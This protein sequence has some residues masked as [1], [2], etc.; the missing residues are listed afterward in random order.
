MFLTQKNTLILLSPIG[1]HPPCPLTRTGVRNNF[2]TDSVGTIICRS[3]FL[4]IFSIHLMIF[5]LITKLGWVVVLIRK[6]R[7]MSKVIYR[8]HTPSDRGTSARFADPPVHAPPT[9]TRGACNT[10]PRNGWCVTC[11]HIAMS[12]YM[13]NPWYYFVRVGNVVDVDCT[14]CC[15]FLWLGNPI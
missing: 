15:A 6:Y 8:L 5:A 1:I 10:V 13:M 4:T 3:Y 14:V 2:I 7:W 9:S 11:T 12:S